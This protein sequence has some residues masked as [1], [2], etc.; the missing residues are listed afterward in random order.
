MISKE[1]KFLGVWKE[2]L[3]AQS[4]S[5]AWRDVCALVERKSEG[6][7]K[8]E[9]KQSR[10]PMRPRQQRSGYALLTLRRRTLVIGTIFPIPNPRTVLS[11]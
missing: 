6:G 4:V 2:V 1:A 10:Q 7:R 3:V 9:Q 8:L 11:T 5:L